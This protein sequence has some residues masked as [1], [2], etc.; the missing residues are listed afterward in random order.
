MDT[1]DRWL[2]SFLAHWNHNRSPV[3]ILYLHGA[4]IFAGTLVSAF[5][6]PNSVY[7]VVCWKAL[8]KRASVGW[9]ISAVGPIPHME[10]ASCRL[11]ECDGCYVFKD[12]RGTLIADL[13]ADHHVQCGFTPQT[14]KLQPVQHSPSRTLVAS[15]T[16][17]A[18]PSPKQVFVTWARE[19]LLSGQPALSAQ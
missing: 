7:F 3:H 19:Q 2:K 10:L 11:I 16:Q 17:L 9:T 1:S 12:A 14:V 13:N 18:S 6:K 15:T 4:D 5:A 8:K